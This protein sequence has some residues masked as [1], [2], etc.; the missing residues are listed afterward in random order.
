MY[1]EKKFRTIG[2]WLA[3]LF[4]LI[5]VVLLTQDFLQKR[6]TQRL[7][8]LRTECEEMAVQQDWEKLESAAREWVKLDE[9]AADGWL[10]LAEAHQ[11]QGRLTDCVECLLKIPKDDPKAPPAMLFAA[12]MQL[13]EARQPSEG[14][15]TL[16]ALRK[17]T[18]RG[19]VVRKHLISLY[20]MT[21]QRQQM[22]DE[23]RDA[24]RYHAEP[25]EAYV[26]LM[27]ADHL[28]FTNGVQL[29]TRW[30]TAE[31]ESELFSVARAVQLIDTLKKLETT[32]PETEFQQ[33]A[34]EEELNSLLKRY[35]ENR[36]LLH[37]RIGSAILDEDIEQVG[38]LLARIPET[39]VL[40]SLSLRYAGWHLMK[41][42]RPQEAEE[43]YRQSLSLMP[44]DW[45]TWH[46][47]ASALRNQG[48][49][50]DAETAAKVAI[51][52]K[53][54]RKDCLSLP[55]AGQPPAQLLDRIFEYAVRCGADDIA[56]ALHFQK[57]PVE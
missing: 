31:P 11:H 1:R 41:T 6:R 30:L 43:A 52:G 7:E 29:N 14:L 47:L 42:Q 57:Q 40:D 39:D 56:S 15:A 8:E 55:D 21:L 51:L 18:P 26:Y 3:G 32:S 44:L 2:V 34:A 25:P 53:E 46:E 36:A 17:L 16:R 5:T 37:Y 50:E 20:A 13:N 22:I 33:K 35:P 12:E 27:I 45:H 28:S 38:Q 49:L 24:F 9:S 19:Q 48:K 23:I 10:N 54:L 4:F